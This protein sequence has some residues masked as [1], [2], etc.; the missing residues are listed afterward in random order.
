MKNQRKQ[1]A[2]EIV[3][4]FDPEKIK[5]IVAEVERHKR[6]KRD[7]IVPAQRLSFADDGSLVFNNR[8]SFKVIDQ[9]YMEW[10][11]AENALSTAQET[12]PDAKI[13]VEQTTNVRLNPTAEQQLAGKLGIPMKYIKSLRKDEHHVRCGTRSTPLSTLSGST[14]TS[15]S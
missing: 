6:S 4:H 11:D 9:I 8:Q 3:S 13:E 7:Y 12:V 10:A 1:P 5:G 2:T 14:S 15:R